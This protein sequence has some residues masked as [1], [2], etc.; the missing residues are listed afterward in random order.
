MSTIIVA[1]IGIFILLTLIVLIVT[2][3]QKLKKKEQ[4]FQQYFQQVLGRYR[5]TIAESEIQR[6]WL[7][8]LDSVSKKLLYIKSPKENP[9]ELL[10]QLS[11]VKTCRVFS[12]TQSFPTGDGGKADVITTLIGLELEFLSGEKI[13]RLPFYD[14]I[15]NSL[16]E[17]AELRG[18]AANWETK[19]KEFIASKNKITVK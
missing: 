13:L 1:V 10:V 15:Q 14:Y 16:P 12:D 7:V 18:K 19:I 8:A 6:H 11:S 2:N 9:Q 3:Q 5:L 17:M 4:A